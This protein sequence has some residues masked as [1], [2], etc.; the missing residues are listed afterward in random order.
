M[1]FLIYKKTSDG[2]T[3]RYYE[4][5]QPIKLSG[6]DGLIARHVRL[7]AACRFDEKK[8]EFRP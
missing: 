1:A 7:A 2:K 5:I 6:R 8:V 3:V 4:K